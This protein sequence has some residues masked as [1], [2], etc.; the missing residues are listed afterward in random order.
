MGPSIWSLY[1]VSASGPI[2]A[3]ASESDPYFQDFSDVFA[4]RTDIMKGRETG[5]EGA[6]G[7]LSPMC[8]RAVAG[9]RKS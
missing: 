5:W 2:S 7:L 1:V 6:G 8:A 3:K 4:R 9:S